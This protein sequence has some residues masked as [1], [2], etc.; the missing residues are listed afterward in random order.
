VRAVRWVTSEGRTNDE[1]IPI[2]DALPGVGIHALEDDEGEVLSIESVFVLVKHC[3]A[4][5]ETGWS[6]RTSAPPNKEELLGALTTHVR[7]LEREL[8][9]D[10]IDEE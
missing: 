10:W 3:D 6:Y 5:G 9:A 1:R 8:V 2:G 7:L 4:L